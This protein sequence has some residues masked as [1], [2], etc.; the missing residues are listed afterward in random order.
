MWPFTVAGPLQVF[1]PGT[2]F[3]FRGR[4]L[5]RRP[6]CRSA[7]GG[8]Q[9]CCALR[10]DLLPGLRRFSFLFSVLFPSGNADGPDSPITAE[11]LSNNSDGPQHKEGNYKMH[12]E[13]IMTTRSVCIYIKV[14][15]PAICLGLLKLFLLVGK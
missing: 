3:E 8:L 2:L 5:S 14:S 15:L 7:V 6:G 1:P 9:G 13:Q 11:R 4:R 10:A 12:T